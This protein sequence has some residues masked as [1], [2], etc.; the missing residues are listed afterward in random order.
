MARIFFKGGGHGLSGPMVN[1][2]TDVIRRPAYARLKLGKRAFSVTEPCAFGISHIP[3]ELKAATDTVA[4]K[5][6]KIIFIL[7]SLPSIK[8]STYVIKSYVQ[9]RHRSLGGNID[10]VLLSI[11]FTV[12]FAMSIFV[13]SLV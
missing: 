12:Y 13:L 6:K 4:F 1:T 9:H 8:F 7:C 3:S 11:H 2:A 5:R 10:F